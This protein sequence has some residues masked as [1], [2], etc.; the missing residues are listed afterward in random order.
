MKVFII[1]NIVRTH[2]S[3]YCTVFYAG[4]SQTYLIKNSQAVKK[5]CA[6]QKNQGEKRCEIKGAG[7]EMA[8]MVG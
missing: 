4:C 3:K 8:V 6:L 7:K 5:G 2:T 1:I